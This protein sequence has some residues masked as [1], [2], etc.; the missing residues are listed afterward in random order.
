MDIYY[1]YLEGFLTAEIE[2]A[3]EEEANKFQAPEWLGEE[4]GYKELSNR[5]LSEMT[6]EE[7]RSKVSEEF[8]KNNKNIIK[9]IKQVINF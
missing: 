7:F 9:K 3:N 5:K 8:I 6:K 1:N 2:F 4:I